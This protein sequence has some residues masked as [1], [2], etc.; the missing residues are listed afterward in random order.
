MKL[1]GRYV[2]QA[3]ARRLMEASTRKAPVAT[4]PVHLTLPMPPSTNRYWTIGWHARKPCLI[5]TKEAERYK[6]DVYLLAKGRV[7][8]LEGP[9]AVELVEHR[10]P[11]GRSDLSNCIKILEDALQGIAYRND[12][13]VV[14]LSLHRGEPATPAVV[15]VMVMRVVITPTG[16]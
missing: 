6:R 14:A 1:R 3:V 2:P 13:Q 8:M 9:I 4:G 7:P 12:S 11:T 15:E 5:P 16:G 10:A